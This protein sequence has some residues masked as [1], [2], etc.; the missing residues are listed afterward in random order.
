MI[1]SLLRRKSASAL[2]VLEVAVGMV[3][4]VNNFAI[5]AYY[6]ALTFAPSGVDEPNLLYVTR[7]LGVQGLTPEAAREQAAADLARLQRIPDI[8][9]AAA[10]D[11]LPFSDATE[12]CT[13]AQTRDWPWSAIVWPM[14]AS[15]GVADALGLHLLRGRAFVP[16]ERGVAIVTSNFAERLLGRQEILGRRIDAEGLP[17]LIVV[18]VVRD[19]RVRTTVAPE[20]R[21]VLLAADLP[22]STRELRYVVRSAPGRLQ[23]VVGR[24]QGALAP[25]QV[26]TRLPDLSAERSHRI[27]RGAII[28]I[29]WMSVIV[30]GVTLAGALAVAS[31][32]V[33]ERTR[34][35]GVRRAL[36]ATRGDIVRYFLIEND[37]VTTLGIAIGLAVALPL[38]ALMS[39]MQLMPAVAWWHVVVSMLLFWVAG[40]VSALV[41]A[42]RAA[43]IPPTAATRTL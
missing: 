5:G 24:V 14:R 4:L 6:A 29:G 40:L 23:A 37:L 15:D 8:V 38:N 22:V 9:G 43:R 27:G 36:G 10:V 28:I 19:F 21:S 12:F 2:L 42:R 35:I 1:R 34:Q 26:A 32:S 31:F 25:G 41:P 30:V 20:N 39:R 16:G 13:V 3:V 18:G 7:R 33:T 17:G 11:E